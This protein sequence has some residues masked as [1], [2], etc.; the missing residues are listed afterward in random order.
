MYE[1]A[2]GLSS[3]IG[4]KNGAQLGFVDKRDITYF[5]R[6]IIEDER[7]ASGHRAITAEDI[8]GETLGDFAGLG[9]PHSHHVRRIV[10]GGDPVYDPTSNSVKY[11]FRIIEGG[12][13]ARLISELRGFSP[14]PSEPTAQMAYFDLERALLISGIA[15]E[16]RSFVLDTDK[17]YFVMATVIPDSKEDIHAVNDALRNN[18]C[19]YPVQKI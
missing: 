4:P 6:E 9:M 2:D 12:S 3:G 1:T 8:R 10:V 15:G 19:Q 16:I 17:G 18:L 14:L 13:R 11:Q 7:V 5:L